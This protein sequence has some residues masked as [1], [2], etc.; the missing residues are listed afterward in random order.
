MANPE[1]QLG[2]VHRIEVELANAEAIESPAL[3]DR[4]HGRHQATRPEIAVQTNEQTAYPVRHRNPEHRFGGLIG[5]E[6]QDA[7]DD[8]DRDPRFLRT[9][10][11]ARIAI[12]IEKELRDR[13]Y[14]AG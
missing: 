14:G 10:Q 5:A 4:D 8:R 3:L 12:D 7:R 1:H 2:L 6:R 9:F 13:P 11:K